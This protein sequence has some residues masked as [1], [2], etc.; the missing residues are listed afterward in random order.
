MGGW[1][2]GE[3]AE[4]DILL[5][6]GGGGVSFYRVKGTQCIKLEQKWNR[7]DDYS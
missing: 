6:G 2:G 1:G 7:S 3:G 5:R 4:L